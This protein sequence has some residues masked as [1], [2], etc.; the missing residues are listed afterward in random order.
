MGA[1][2]N[3]VLTPWKK[4]ERKEGFLLKKRRVSPFHQNVTVLTTFGVEV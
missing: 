1:A 2:L 3:L 4:K